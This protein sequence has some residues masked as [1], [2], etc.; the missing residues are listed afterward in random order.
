MF[1][2]FFHKGD[3]KKEKKLVSQYRK[4]AIFTTS[5]EFQPNDTTDHYRI[6]GVNEVNKI[7]KKFKIY[8]KL[9]KKKFKIKKN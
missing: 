3:D 6:V 4:V 2:S 9:I 8:K 5:K 7:K 1:E